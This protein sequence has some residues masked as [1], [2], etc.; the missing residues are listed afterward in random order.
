MLKNFF[1]LSRQRSSNVS[2]SVFSVNILQS[3][4]MLESNTGA[5][6]IKP[7]TDAPVWSKLLASLANIRKG[8]KYF[9]RTNTLAY[10]LQ[11]KGRKKS[12]MPLTPGAYSIKHF[13]II[14]ST[15]L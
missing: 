5:S 14:F 7:L 6:L 4:L 9:P 2:L 12:F 10:F 11:R 8:C 3:Y 13:S 15:E 1:S